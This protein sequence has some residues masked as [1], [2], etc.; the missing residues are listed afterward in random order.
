MC[1]HTSGSVTSAG[2]DTPIN[3]MCILCVNHFYYA[4]GILITTQSLSTLYS[5]LID[6]FS[7]QLH[8]YWANACACATCHVVYICCLYHW[9]SQEIAHLARRWYSAR[10]HARWLEFIK[11]NGLIFF[12]Y[13]LW[14]C[15]GCGLTKTWIDTS[16]AATDTEFH[17]FSTEISCSYFDR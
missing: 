6:L 12:F 7:F 9:R 8:V 10:A 17:T 14:L 1:M 5:D 2:L 4:V 16:I 3:C 15:L 13:F 11:S